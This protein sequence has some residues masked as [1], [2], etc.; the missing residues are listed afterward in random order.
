MP[1]KTL[2]EIQITEIGQHYNF[3]K[4]Y[5]LVKQRDQEYKKMDLTRGLRF[6]QGEPLQSSL[7]AWQED[8]YFVVMKGGD[9]ARF[10]WKLEII[11]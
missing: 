6:Q 9:I 3:N 1:R 11:S 5:L 10:N 2:V 4:P 7:Y 8:R